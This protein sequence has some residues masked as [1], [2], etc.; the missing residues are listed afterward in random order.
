[1]FIE[2]VNNISISKQKVIKDA[3]LFFASKLIPARLFPLLEIDIN[4]T[5]SSAD[6]FCE[7]TDSNINPRSFTIELN[8]KL[9]GDEL[10][11]TIAHEMVHVKQYVKGELKERY[12][13]H[14]HHL[15]HKELIII[16]DKNWYDVPWE[17]EAR[18]LEEK[19]FNEYRYMNDDSNDNR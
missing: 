18:D 12:K 8:K 14:H 4:V 7:Y 16:N 11:K 10:V 19:L 5:K 17:V 15:W 13:P 6:G 2:F 9:K 3:A 1:M